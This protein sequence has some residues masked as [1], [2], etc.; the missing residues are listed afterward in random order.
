[1][2]LIASSIEAMEMASDTLIPPTEFSFCDKLTKSVYTDS[3]DFL[4]LEINSTDIS[5]SL[6][7]EKVINIKGPCVKKSTLNS[8]LMQTNREIKLLPIAVMA[9]PLRYR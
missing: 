6:R 3:I 7:E 1:M 9:E 4:G 8:S 2:L 5:V